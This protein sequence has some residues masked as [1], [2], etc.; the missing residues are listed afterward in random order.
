[1]SDQP[2]QPPTVSCP[3]P[4]LARV[5]DAASEWRAWAD[6]QAHELRH[7]TNDHME[8]AE[9]QLYDAVRAWEGTRRG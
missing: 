3:P 6:Q 7:M 9:R 1:M 8:P 5:L 2:V 4:S